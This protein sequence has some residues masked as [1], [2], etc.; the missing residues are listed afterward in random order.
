MGSIGIG[1]TD[2]LLQR[3]KRK[4]REAVEVEDCIW[5]KEKPRVSDQKKTEK[6]TISNS[7]AFSRLGLA[8][9][10][11][12]LGRRRASV[13]PGNYFRSTVHSEGKQSLP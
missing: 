12:T 8:A 6:D 1:G 5:T 2:P 13:G 9:L 10:F 11:A 4:R 7:R 3:D